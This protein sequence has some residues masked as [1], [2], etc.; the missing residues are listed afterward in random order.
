MVVSQTFVYL[1]LGAAFSLGLQV[2]ALDPG[3]DK[4]LRFLLGSWRMPEMEHLGLIALCGIIAAAGFYGITQGYR[5]VASSVVA[6][7]EYTA[8]IW[9]AALGYLL[10]GDIP[11]LLAIAGATLIIGSGI[12]II[13]RET[14]K[15]AHSDPKPPRI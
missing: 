8:L 3:D 9:A 11:D 15:A 2:L 1:V 10:W 12:Y 13:H 7:F 5:L 6:P 14:V 4:T